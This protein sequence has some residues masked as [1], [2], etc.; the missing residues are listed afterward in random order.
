MASSAQPTSVPQQ[1]AQIE[2][3][4]AP[5]VAQPQPS[6]QTPPVVQPQAATPVA[7]QG[8]TKPSQPEAQKTSRFSRAKNF[9]SNLFSTLVP[10][11]FKDWFSK[12]TEPSATEENSRNATGTKEGVNA[13]EELDKITNAGGN[14]GTAG[15]AGAPPTDEQLKELAELEARLDEHGI[16][17]T[18][19]LFTEEEK[20][21][22]DEIAND[23]S[24]MYAQA[25]E[26][27]KIDPLEETRLAAE[28]YGLTTQNKETNQALLNPLRWS[29]EDEA[30]ALDELNALKR[31]TNEENQKP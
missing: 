3:Q 27:L 2:A 8:P 25:M 20:Q 11:M 14:S 24:S 21:E 16:K 1:N 15:N 30:K 7:E 18:K 4:A 6:E 12:K 22:L 9:I 5:P 13:L 10:K 19:A 26:E 29:N 23:A 31:Q 28:L 17:G